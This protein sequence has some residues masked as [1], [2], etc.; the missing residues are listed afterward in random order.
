L[1][2][3]NVPSSVSTTVRHRRAAD[4]R[5][6]VG[7]ASYCDHTGIVFIGAIAHYPSHNIGGPLC[8]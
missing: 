8:G 6:S 4:H 3:G 2:V 1:T 5:K 7:R